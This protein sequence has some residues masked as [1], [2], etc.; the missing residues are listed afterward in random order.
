MRRGDGKLLAWA[1]GPGIRGASHFSPSLSPDFILAKKTFVGN[2][3]H[4][5]NKLLVTLL[6]SSSLDFSTTKQPY[7]SFRI[8]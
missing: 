6:L 3:T 5:K 2:T 1:T 7:F 4:A 8:N